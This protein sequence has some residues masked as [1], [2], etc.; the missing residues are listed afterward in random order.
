MSA[1]RPRQTFWELLD[2]P[3]QRRERAR[4]LRAIYALVDANGWDARRLAAAGPVEEED[5]A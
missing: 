4:I 5:A 2:T 3:E 1:G